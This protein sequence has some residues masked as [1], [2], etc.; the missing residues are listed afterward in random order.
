MALFKAEALK[1]GLAPSNVLVL[2]EWGSLLLQECSKDAQTWEENG[3]SLV[4][5]HARLLELLAA[6][7]PKTGTKK[8][9]L[10]VTRRALRSLLKD[11]ATRDGR[12]EKIVTHLASKGPQGYKTAVM[13]GAVAGVCARLPQT[14]TS[15][16]SVNGV[17]GSPF[18]VLEGLKSYYYTFWVREVIGSKSLVPKHIANAFHDF[19]L[20]FTTIEDLQREIVPA[21]E[22]ALL[23]AP[24]VVLNDLVSPLIN[25]LPPSLDL[26]G[27]LANHLLKPL[28]SS[29][30]SSNAEIRN[31]ALRALAT[32]LK[33]SKDNES[34]YN[35]MNEILKPLAA[36]KLPSAE[37]RV[38]HAKILEMLPSSHSRSSKICDGL[39]T[40]ISKEPNEA[41]IAAEVGALTA[42]LT[43]LV[44]ED[45]GYMVSLIPLF[46]K[47]LHDKKQN[48][49]KIWALNAGQMLWALKDDS[50]TSASTA[51][52]ENIVP[53]LLD[54]FGEIASNPLQATQ[55]GLITVN[56]IVI[57][58]LSW[59]QTTK[60]DSTKSLLLKA[61]VVEQALICEPKPSFFLNHR[62]YTKL[63][64]KEDLTWLVRAVAS[65]TSYISSR[66]Q[67]PESGP[68]TAL[69]QA[70]IYTI[71]APS[72]NF[73]TRRES[74][75]A[76]S[77]QCQSYPDFVSRMM[78]KGL[79]SWLQNLYL[80]VKDSPAY[81]SQSGADRLG[82]VL[83]IIPMREEAKASSEG[84]P[85]TK[86]SEDQLCNFLVLCR[87]ELVPR[88]SWI[89]LCL[90]AGQD[91]G[92]L[93]TKKHRQCVEKVN[94]VLETNNSAETPLELVEFAAYNTLAELAFVAPGS[95]LPLLVAQVKSDLSLDDF[96]AYTPQDF[97]IARTPEGT[98]FIDVLNKKG[99]AETI[100]KGS[101]DYELLKW[102]AEVRAQQSAKKGQ[103]KKL[104]PDE[105]AKV[106]A[107]LSKEAS[108]RMKVRQL[109]RQI[110]RGI[111]TIKALAL[112][113]PTD[114]ETWMGQTVQALIDII[115]AGVG[116]L[117]GESASEAFIVCADLVAGRLGSLR[118][119]I[120]VATLRS[121]GS[122]Y[123]PNYLLQ[124]S[125]G[126]QLIAKLKI[127]AKF[128]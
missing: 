44:S 74:A 59:W 17:V 110:R 71:V 40:I 94:L 81:L 112:G 2:V 36:S 4:T 37:L 24:E 76:L 8:S 65:C 120:G 109:E 104:T 96:H 6:L 38:S 22:K 117:V 121:L 9:A 78:I 106:N 28:L 16:T 25:P 20:A 23:R 85:Y 88:S 3:I 33:R 31:G 55:S 52:L 126:G 115:Q 51:I 75:K 102:E 80:E 105:Q 114:T 13:L 5:A 34:L 67:D 101:N 47:G 108:I 91:P 27:I 79:W 68:C 26:A 45:P 54:L 15:T 77:M 63:A 123:L 93:V 103:Q 72:V 46:T 125:I 19:L 90:E 49:Q 97:A 1:E 62:V 124:E 69:A 86:V 122:S 83:H 57:G 7:Q 111:G 10:V 95:I 48:V 21:L 11:D 61:K 56:Y 116:L 41:A 84:V 87:P 100:D 35:I 113:P 14:S 127:R 118:Q 50:F 92:S 43:S 99:Q 98:T 32:L 128:I 42:H 53:K 60:N 29:L 70:W 30:K 12:I 39:S 119:F 89:E 82:T 73:E 58:I 66:K 64:S 107:Q 18:A